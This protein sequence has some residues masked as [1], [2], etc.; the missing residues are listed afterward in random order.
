MITFADARNTL[1]AAVAEAGRGARQTTSTLYADCLLREAIEMSDAPLD[2]TTTAGAAA[3]VAA[4]RAL[5]E[6]R[7]AEGR[8]RA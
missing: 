8:K 2:I 7:Q 4:A 3:A 1:I 5:W 6:R